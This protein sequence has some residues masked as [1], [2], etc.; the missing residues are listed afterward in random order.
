MTTH[1]TDIEKQIMNG[2]P[3][4]AHIAERQSHN[5]MLMTAVISTVTLA[6]FGL[7]AAFWL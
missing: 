7:A 3:R 6:V 5:A 4:L 1:A 2:A